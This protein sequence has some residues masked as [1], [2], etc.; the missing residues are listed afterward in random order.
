MSSQSDG[1]GRRMERMHLT[2]ARLRRF[3]RAE[4]GAATV[5][6]VVGTA[7][8]VGLTLAVAGSVRDGVEAVATGIAD[9][10][11]GYQ[12]DTGFDD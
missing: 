2:A 8:A 5:D 7:G 3:V 6:W 9:T 12:I 1:I 10:V 4:E 11:G